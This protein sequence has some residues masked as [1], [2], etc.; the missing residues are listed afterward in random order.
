M[1]YDEAVVERILEAYH[2]LSVM[3]EAG[4]YQQALQECDKWLS[5]WQDMPGEYRRVLEAERAILSKVVDPNYAPP[6]YVSSVEYEPLHLLSRRALREGRIEESLTRLWDYLQYVPIGTVS[7]LWTIGEISDIALRAGHERL[8]KAA[9]H[10]FLAHLRFMEAASENSLAHSEKLAEHIFSH[11]DEV[12]LRFINEEDEPAWAT[13]LEAE[14]REAEDMQES[15]KGEFHHELPFSDHILHVI[16][17]L[18][19]YYQRH[20]YEERLQSLLQK[21][22]EAQRFLQEGEE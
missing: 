22:P 17:A 2:R 16:G 19:R 18:A 14:L 8:A 12:A 21:Y 3:K 10:L 4:E 13:I 15:I 5:E 1:Q 9:A 11:P 20:G 6:P 7:F